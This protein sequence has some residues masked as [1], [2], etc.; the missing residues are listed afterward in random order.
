MENNKMKFDGIVKVWT[1][2]PYSSR[3]AQCVGLEKAKWDTYEEK[4]AEHSRLYAKYDH[5]PTVHFGF[6]N[7][8]FF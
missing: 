5:L 7:M 4:N 2:S 8:L 1:A 3:N 6:T